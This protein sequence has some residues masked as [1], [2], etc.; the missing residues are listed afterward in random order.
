MATVNSSDH[1]CSLLNVKYSLKALDDIA[2]SSCME[3]LFDTW[4]KKDILNLMI[5]YSN[6]HQ[7][8]TMKNILQE[9]AVISNDFNNEQQPPSNKFDAI[10]NQSIVNV[11][12]YL[13]PNDV[14][15]LKITSLRLAILC[16]QTTN[17]QSQ[18]KK[19]ALTKPSINASLHLSKVTLKKAYLKSPWIEQ[20]RK[21][22]KHLSST[23]QSY[24]LQA[25][26]SKCDYTEKI[27]A[28]N[29]GC[30]Q[31]LM[32]IFNYVNKSTVVCL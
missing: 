24:K 28:Q 13:T 15:Q 11:I 3:T 20:W 5:K 19:F 32:I 7:L 8:D 27:N 30:I 31:R 29:C 2:L 1:L 25:S 14:Y 12:S 6:K 17:I 9:A 26:A 10:S 16:L 23:G 21:H 22:I 4:S 18:N